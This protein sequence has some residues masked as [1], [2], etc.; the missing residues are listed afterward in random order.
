M[1][2]ERML[3]EQRV[4]K[5]KRDM[6]NWEDNANAILKEMEERRLAPQNP[7]TYKDLGEEL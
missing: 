5:A 7:Q 3:A 4:A 2:L 6:K 1:N